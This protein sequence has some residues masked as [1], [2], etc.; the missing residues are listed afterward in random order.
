MTA[1]RLHVVRL[2]VLPL[3]SCL[4]LAAGC[5]RQPPQPPAK[6]PR[7]TFECRFTEDPVSI[8][9]KLDDAAWQRAVLIDSFTVPWEKGGP[10]ARKGTRARLLWDRDNLYVAADM[11]DTDLYA[12]VTEHDGNTWDNDVFEVF[13]KPSAD[14]PAYYE[15]HV[16]PANTVFDLFLP[17]RGHVGRFKKLGEFDIESAVAL[18]GTLDRWNDKDKGWSVEMRIPWESLAETGGRPA[19]GDEW[20][21]ALCRY[22]YDLEHEAPE[23]SSS[24]PLSRRD[25][26]R[27]EDYAAVRFTGPDTT[28]QQP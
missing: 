19:A 2:A 25:F 16:T 13:L 6:P 5:A 1:L 10:A 28:A 12:D 23:L 14:K 18:R 24:A 7:P 22:D 20:R 17:R 9:G 15:F 3:G 21:I 8:D 26:H 27:H 4:A 11:D